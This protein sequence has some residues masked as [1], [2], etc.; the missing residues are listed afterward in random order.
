VTS[1]ASDFVI[2]E[3]NQQRFETTKQRMEQI[4]YAIIGDSSRSLNGQPTISGFIADTGRLP[5][6]IQ[7]LMEDV[8][9]CTNPQFTNKEDC[10]TPP[11]NTPAFTSGDWILASCSNATLTT[12]AACEANDD[13]WA[14]DHNWQRPYIPK[15]SNGLF[16]DA[17]GSAIN[18][19]F[20]ELEDISNN[21]QERRLVI[22]SLG[23]DKSTG[24]SSSNDD[25]Q[26]EQDIIEVIGADDYSI[27]GVNIYVD[28]TDSALY[29]SAEALPTIT[30]LDATG[31]SQFANLKINESTSIDK[32]IISGRL[33]VS[34][35]KQKSGE[36]L[37]C[38]NQTT[39]EKI[40]K[41]LYFHPVNKEYIAKFN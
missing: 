2:N 7:N 9:Y 22:S 4:R 17:W 10:E 30:G 26:Y 39:Y 15:D 1:L 20:Y 23:L 21:L 3:T 28:V 25:Q 14:Y 34:V 8:A 24:T 27:E 6:S 18:V 16:L 32:K 13:M 38:N 5:A 36:T 11:P 40:Q 35:N 31:V 37:D 19:R 12:Q 41:S 29:C 33:F